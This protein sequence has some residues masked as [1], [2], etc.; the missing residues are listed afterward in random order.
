MI[1]ATNL[2]NRGP[3]YIIALETVVNSDVK[4]FIAFIGRANFLS[5]K[6]EFLIM[7]L[8]IDV[9]SFLKIDLLIQSSCEQ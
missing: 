9:A 7:M 1:I 5:R 6:I 3:Y 8:I 2:F 4:K